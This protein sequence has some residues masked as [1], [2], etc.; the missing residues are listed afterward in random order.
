MGFAIPKSPRFR[1][2]RLPGAPGQTVFRCRLETSLVG[3]HP[4]AFVPLT[5]CVIWGEQRGGAPR[6]IAKPKVNVTEVTGEN[7][8]ADATVNVTGEVDAL[9]SRSWTSQ[10]FA[11]RN[12]QYGCHAQHKSW[13]SSF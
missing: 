3:T 4:I 12:L 13:P 9:R 1:G 5:S 8:I 6:E 11:R 7:E 2:S 10:L